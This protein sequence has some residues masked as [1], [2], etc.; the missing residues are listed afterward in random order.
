M[1]HLRFFQGFQ[2]VELTLKGI[3]SQDQGRQ[4]AKLTHQ[5]EVLVQDRG[6]GSDRSGNG[7]E[8]CENGRKRGE[9]L[10]KARGKHRN[11]CPEALG[12]SRF[13]EE[14]TSYKTPR[15]S[16]SPLAVSP[17]A[18]APSCSTEVE[19]AQARWEALVNMRLG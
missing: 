15:P 13:H 8:R 1:K 17:A 3:W 6:Q 10:R 14:H 2:G 9:N 4:I 18:K 5:V 7:R 11:P 12:R 19:I 16:G